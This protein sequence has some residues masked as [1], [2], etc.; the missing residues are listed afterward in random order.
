MHNINTRLS[1]ALA[2]LAAGLVVASFTINNAALA[3]T[4]TC[5]MI[6]A[7]GTGCYAPTSAKCSWYGPNFGVTWYQAEVCTYDGQRL[8]GDNLTPGT[9]AASPNKGCCNNLDPQQHCPT[10]SCPDG[11]VPPGCTSP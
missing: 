8:T 6:A 3:V 7:G 4:S 9:C 5:H 10:T 11:Y 1:K 2:L